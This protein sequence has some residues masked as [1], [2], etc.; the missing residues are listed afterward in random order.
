LLS[1]LAI[2]QEATGTPASSTPGAIATPSGQTFPPGVTVKLPGDRVVTFDRVAMWAE[3][4]DICLS[5]CPGEL[6][7]QYT[8]LY[9]DP[10]KVEALVALTEQA[11]WELTANFHLAYPYAQPH[12]RWYPR[13]Q[14]SGPEYV[15]QWVDDFRANRARGRSRE[16]AQDPSFRAWLVE[17]SYAAAGDLANL[18]E[19]L[20]AKASR[21]Q[22]QIRPSVRVTRTWSAAAAA[23]LD[24]TQVRQ[25][26]DQVLTALGEPT[27]GALASPT[28]PAPASTNTEKADSAAETFKNQGD[29]GESSGSRPKTG[30]V[31][32][33]V[34]VSYS[35]HDKPQADAVCARLE[36]NG[37][38]CWIAPRD[39]VPGQEWG[40]AIVDAI[41][42]SRVM[43]LVFSRHANASPQ[44]RREV[45][46]AVSAETVLIPFRIEAVV[47]SQSL[48]Y[49]LGTPHW[50]DALTPPFEAHLERLAAAVASFLA[51]TEPGDFVP[52]DPAGAQF[53]GTRMAAPLDVPQPVEREADPTS[54][55]IPSAADVP[56]TRTQTRV[57][58]TSQP[59]QPQTVKPS[60]ESAQRLTHPVSPRGK[61]GLF[62]ALVAI[63]GT[64]LLI[65]GGVFGLLW[66]THTD[67]GGGLVYCGRPADPDLSSAVRADGA[68]YRGVP[69]SAYETQCRA[70]L[71]ARYQ[72]AVPV[73]VVGALAVGCALVARRRS[74]A[75]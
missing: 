40:A 58:A 31:A 35:H 50:L 36:A 66:T 24:A 12:L 63:F 70:L 6:K 52:G 23:K 60:V 3:G 22:I 28:P 1:L 72:W 20:S 30:L 8:R 9:S 71:H 11:G 15:R 53:P 34:F 45:E 10:A 49:F 19:W 67:A 17:R 68:H 32:R 51:T 26:I 64:A 16:R 18:D 73:T 59:K 33:D 29:L 21:I 2:L 55:T 38:R 54:G 4:E 14:L 7:P 69:P 75:P 27:L 62:V 65:Y 41:R 37:I 13:P 74:P 44:V 57:G 39:I 61:R 48:E 25:A 5:M 47:P 42:S 43:V 46:R 56:A